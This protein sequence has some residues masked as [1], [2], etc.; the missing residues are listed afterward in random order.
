[1]F[2][3][4]AFPLSKNTLLN[5]KLRQTY[6]HTYTVN[7]YSIICSKAYTHYV[8]FHHFQCTI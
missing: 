2:L 5:I 7:K 6:I 1:M 3:N 8:T 4:N